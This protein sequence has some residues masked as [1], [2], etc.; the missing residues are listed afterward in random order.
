[1]DSINS[2]VQLFE[3]EQLPTLI[4]YI[5]WKTVTNSFD[6]LFQKMSSNLASMCEISDSNRR[7]MDKSWTRPTFLQLKG[8]GENCLI[9]QKYTV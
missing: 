8:E 2:V 9:F 6:V 4:K 7:K 5:N 1:M 3:Y